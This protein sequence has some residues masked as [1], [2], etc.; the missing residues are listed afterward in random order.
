MW[1]RWEFGVWW[2]SLRR[3]VL[4]RYVGRMRGSASGAELSRLVHMAPLGE[5]VG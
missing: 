4:G 5:I 2:L 3:G 1:A